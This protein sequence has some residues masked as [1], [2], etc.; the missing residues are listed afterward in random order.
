MIRFHPVNSTGPAAGGGSYIRW[1]NR[2]LQDLKQDIEGL[3]AAGQDDSVQ[4]GATK[5]GA[6]VVPS[7][8]K[9]VHQTPVTL[10]QLL[11]TLEAV[12]KSDAWVTDRQGVSLYEDKN[13]KVHLDVVNFAGYLLKDDG[14]IA[15][16]SVNPW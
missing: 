3:R 15:S 9:E 12:E 14:G 16:R 13:G 11:T 1:E 7:S 10:G 8:T 4:L 5:D 6:L 2:S